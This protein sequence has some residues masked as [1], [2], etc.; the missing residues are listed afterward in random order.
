MIDKPVLR[1]KIEANGEPAHMFCRQGEVLMIPFRGYVE[2]ELFK[3]IVLPCGV[4]TQIV[5]AAGVRSMSARYMLEGKDSDGQ[6]CHIYIE[7]NGWFDDRTKTMPFHTVPTIYTDSKCLA[8][9]LNV[10][11]FTGMGIEREDG[12]W[13]EFYEIDQ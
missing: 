13:I 6:D 8:P 11:Q 3:G 10:N 2:S 9:Y 7:N 12:L 1:I 5:N 4:D